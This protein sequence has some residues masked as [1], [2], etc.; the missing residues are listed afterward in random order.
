[1]NSWH[2]S[3][4]LFRLVL[5]IEESCRAL[6][7]I[8]DLI[9]SS[10]EFFSIFNQIS[11]F[12]L[13]FFLV[14][15][16]KKHIVFLFTALIFSKNKVNPK[17][18]VFADK[19]TLKSSSHCDDKFFSWWS[20]RRQYHVINFWS[21]HLLPKLD[22][23]NIFQKSG[24]IEKLRNQLFDIRCWRFAHKSVPNLIYLT[25][26]SVSKVKSLL[27]VPME[28]CKRLNPD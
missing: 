3:Y 7:E 25:E 26:K 20:P 17:M 10:F 28:S 6:S 11:P 2:F 21:F 24:H 23:S 18:K 15:C 1:M 4:Y 5:F 13:K 22:I 8:C 9:H 19:I 14:S 12:L 27:H 16:W